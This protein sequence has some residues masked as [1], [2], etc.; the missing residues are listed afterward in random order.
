MAALHDE[1]PRYEDTDWERI[2]A[3][4]THLERL[5]GNPVVRV[6]LAVA[7]AMVD[8]PDAGSPCSTR[9]RPPVPWTART[10]ST[11]SRLHLLEQK[12]DLEGAKVAY[13]AAAGAS[14]NGHERDYLTMRA[15]ALHGLLPRQRDR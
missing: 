8:G 3:L 2:L 14:L 6:D 10:A 15:A 7:A 4:Y 5:S 12:G 9:S 13:V 1:A 11:P